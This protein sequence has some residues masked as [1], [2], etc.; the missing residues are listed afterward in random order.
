MKNYKGKREEKYSFLKDAFCFS[1]MVWALILV[2]IFFM[3]LSEISLLKEQQEQKEAKNDQTVKII[4]VDG[5]LPGDDTEASGYASLEAMGLE[6]EDLYE[7]TANFVVTSYCGCSKC[8]GKWSSGSDSNAIGC[9]GVKL[10]PYYSIAVDKSIIPLGTV[11]WD[12]EGNYYRAEDTGSG[13]KGHH[14]D[15]FTGDH[16]AAL[17]AGVDSIRL[18]W[19]D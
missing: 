2:Y 4:S 9:L 6:V 14:I 1:I 11:L 3:H 8:C 17:Q 13:V 10:T 19:N 15:V 16:E 5:S 7:H 18:Y 12:D